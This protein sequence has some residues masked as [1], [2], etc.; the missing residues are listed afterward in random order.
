MPQEPASARLSRLA[1][2]TCGVFR[3]ESA[4]ALGVMPNQLTRL[5]RQQFIATW[6]K[7]VH[8]PRRL[9]HELRT[10]MSATRGRARRAS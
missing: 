1:A 3:A 5:T 9:I 4:N 2:P 6:D 10:T 8:D 7:V